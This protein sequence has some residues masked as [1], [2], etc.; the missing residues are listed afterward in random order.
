MFQIIWASK[1]Q[2]LF[3]IHEEKNNVLGL[4][5][6]ECK[7][8]LNYKNSVAQQNTHFAE[9]LGKR[10]YFETSFSLSFSP[11]IIA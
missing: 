1:R 3:N 9:E 2:R 7:N 6:N 8:S 10:L 5:L 11:E 4:F